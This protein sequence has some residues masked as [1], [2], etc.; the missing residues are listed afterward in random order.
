MPD[1]PGQYSS[2][3]GHSRPP[4]WR[5]GE[6]SN[7]DGII[8][9]AKTGDEKAWSTLY[10]EL[11]RPL[12]GYLRLRGTPDPENLLGEVFLRLARHL[13][14]F[15]GDLSGL[16]AYAMTIAANLVRDTARRQAARPNL[17]LVDPSRMESVEPHNRLTSG[18]AESMVLGSAAFS[19]LRPLFALLTADQRE[20][21]YLRFIGDLSVEQTAK[22]LGRSSGAIKQLQHRA[23]ERLRDAM[24]SPEPGAT[25]EVRP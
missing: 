18:S 22:A 16:K 10:D 4:G 15:R 13:H 25:P 17:T 2:G 23:I 24:V 6:G 7:D 21:L 19:N 9:A 8:E 12:L 20:V 5:T 14:R 11:H 1:D 3:S